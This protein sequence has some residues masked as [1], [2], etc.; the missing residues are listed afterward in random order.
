MFTFV[1]SFG[2]HE[3]EY[4]CFIYEFVIKQLHIPIFIWGIPYECVLVKREATSTL[5]ARSSTDTLPDA[6]RARN[7]AIQQL[8][9]INNRGGSRIYGMVWL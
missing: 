3:V 5:L 2:S 6:I 1:Y 8:F 4:M 7:Y 9:T